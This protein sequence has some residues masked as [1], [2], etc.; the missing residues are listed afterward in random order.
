MR[1]IALLDCRVHSAQKLH[2]GRNQRAGLGIR[3]IVPEGHA[4]PV[5]V[6]RRSVDKRKATASQPAE[7]KVAT[8]ENNFMVV[9][10]AKD[11][12]QTEIEIINN[13]QPAITPVFHNQYFHAHVM[14]SPGVNK[15]EVRW[16]RRGAGG[17][18]SGDWD[19]KAISIFRYLQAEGPPGAE[20]PPYL[21]HTPEKEKQC[22]W[23]HQL[24]LT[25]EELDSGTD[26]TCLV[27]HSDLQKSVH[28]HGP[29]GVGM[30]AACHD[31]KSR[32]NRYRIGKDDNVLCYSCHDDRKE[33]DTKKKFMHGPVGAGMCTVCHDPHGSPNEY[34]LIKTKGRAMR[35]VPSGRR[36]PLA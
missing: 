20:Y 28:V 22:E 14:L 8:T 33:T 29:V 3:I 6:S 11:G 4:A 1:A 25:P 9:G 5:S 27:C 7:T 13:G 16:R 32:P 35:N 2:G 36:G 21:F 10:V 30:C 18:A 19:V 15:I 17:P 31:P 12:A 24:T 34:Q 23:C 26:N